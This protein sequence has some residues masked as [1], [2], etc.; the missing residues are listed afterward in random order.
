MTVYTPIGGSSDDPTVQF[1][2]YPPKR[3]ANADARSVTCPW[4]EFVWIATP[5]ETT[6]KHEQA[7][8]TKVGITTGKGGRTAAPCGNLVVFE[9]DKPP[10]GATNRQVFERCEQVLAGHYAVLYTS[11]SATEQDWRF[12]GV[13]LASRAPANAAEY[14][15]CVEFLGQ[16]MFGYR[17]ADESFKDTQAWYRPITGEA[18]SCGPEIRRFDGP[19]VLDVDE[20][21]RLYPP[22]KR[23][24]PRKVRPDQIAGVP[25]RERIA[26]ASRS[27]EKRKKLHSFELAQRCI[28]FALDEDSFLAVARAYAT[29]E[30]WTEFDEGEVLQRYENALQHRENDPGCALWPELKPARPDDIDQARR[31]LADAVASAKAPVLAISAPKG[32]GKTW[33]SDQE[34]GKVDAALYVAP[35]R[36]LVADAGAR[37]GIHTHEHY[38]PFK[39]GSAE[40]SSVPFGPKNATSLDSLHKLVAKMRDGAIQWPAVVVLDEWPQLEARLHQGKGDKRATLRALKELLGQAERVLAMSADMTAKDI[41]RLRT[42]SGRDVADVDLAHKRVN[43]RTI[44]EVSQAAARMAIEEALE[45]RADHERIAIFVHSPREL[46][47]LR[48]SLLLRWPRL[49]VRAIHGTR[50]DDVEDGAWDVL[51]FN[52]A[53]SA[54]VSID[55]EVQQLFMTYAHRGLGSSE[56]MQAAGRAR[57]LADP[58]ILV[59]KPQWHPSNRRSDA[60]HRLLQSRDAY[61]NAPYQDVDPEIAQSYV[62]VRERQ[63]DEWNAADLRDA[64]ERC[65][66]GWIDCHDRTSVARAVR[67]RDETARKIADIEFARRG[68]NE[69]LSA[70]T[71]VKDFLGRE[72]SEEQIVANWT[73]KFVKRMHRWRD[74]LDPPDP[75]WCNESDSDLSSRE[76]RRETALAG[77]EL[78]KRATRSEPSIGLVFAPYVGVPVLSGLEVLGPLPSPEKAEDWVRTELA[79]FG[80]RLRKREKDGC[81]LVIA[82]TGDDLPSTAT[83]T[84]SAA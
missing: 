13:V 44:L 51:L 56:V 34:I 6:N 82:P 7:F 76:L 17:P 30:T 84:T 3:R 78:Y 61:P 62:D 46:E 54:G 20:A 50:R 74:V 35:G 63:T 1:S 60:V 22:P 48:E 42:L 21:V 81:A 45:V 71:H 14:R 37:L 24:R 28:D 8:S 11:A 57:V 70:Y 41:E 52:T 66:W 55:V 25:M 64:C 43:L 2:I 47:T 9:F 16:Q 65:G 12:R 59:G 33:T 32:I 83:K 29:K 39:D 67:E 31:E 77:R 79:K 23:G 75:R 40:R 72:P 19:Q 5:I 10:P 18:R 68:R 15:S 58:R 27:I 26:L 49:R 73:G 36:K 69:G 4:S 38:W 80:C 53:A